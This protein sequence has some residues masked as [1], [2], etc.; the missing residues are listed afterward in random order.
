[1]KN[2]WIIQ[3]FIALAILLASCTKEGVVYDE[4]IPSIK[5]YSPVGESMYVA[6]DTVD[7]HVEITDND[8]L[9]EIEATLIANNQGAEELVWEVATHSH[10]ASYDLYYRLVIPPNTNHTDYKL[11]IIASDHHENIGHK[12]IT[13]HV[14]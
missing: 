1:M 9:H 11:E 3:A 5:V 10:D 6:G 2:K 13:F 12:S 4:D 14:M 7:I 8:E